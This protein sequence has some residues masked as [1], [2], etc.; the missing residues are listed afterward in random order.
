MQAPRDGGGSHML[1]EGKRAHG[2]RMVTLESGAVAESI[3][4]GIEGR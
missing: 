1:L 2:I 3:P 4:D